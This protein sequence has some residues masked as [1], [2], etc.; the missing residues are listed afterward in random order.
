MDIQIT[1]AT[2]HQGTSWLI[3]ARTLD[4]ALNLERMPR[5]TLAI[6]AAEYDLDPEDP[7]A[8]DL[9]LLERFYS[10]ADPEEIHP[11]FAAPSVAAAERAMRERIA[12][13]QDA[14]GAPVGKLR[15]LAAAIA[16]GKATEGA[17]KAHRHL[18]RGANPQVRGAVQF[19]RDRE[20]ERIQNLTLTETSLTDQLLNQARAAAA[21][22]APAVLPE[23][24]PAPERP[25]LDLLRPTT[26]RE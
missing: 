1:G 16:A 7:F 17:G 18:Q 9:V 10:P 26:L 5:E 23:P 2:V 8:L 15:P 19:L 20:R 11:L 12:E 24:A 22:E 13:V 6:R 21:P 3:V 14:H 4:G 25:K